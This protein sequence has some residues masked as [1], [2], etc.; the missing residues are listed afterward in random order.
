MSEL[1]YIPEHVHDLMAE[2]AALSNEELG[3]FMRL[4]WALWD[5]G[6]Y[7]PKR[8]VQ[9]A[10]QA[11]SAWE[12]IGPAIMAKLTQAGRIVS[13]S[14]LLALLSRT[15]ERHAK[16]VDRAERA[17]AARWSK[18][19]PN[20]T[21]G[22]KNNEINE[23]TMLVAFDKHANQNQNSINSKSLSMD[24]AYEDGAR[25][26]T[27]RA[28]IRN[29][30]ARSQVAKWIAAAGDEELAAILSAVEREG[31]KGPNLVAVVDQ[32]VA[33]IVRLQKRGPPLPFGPS[34]IKSKP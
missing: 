8:E 5:A 9:K 18:N 7:L 26:L 1:P 4:R 15:R 22:E 24:R 23:N 31:L 25:L 13:S 10:T 6:G 32:R 29:L 19:A 21:S 34:L 11:G 28:G 20:F 12:M 14:S 27:D 3:A 16:A 30:A 33:M 17:A 2:T